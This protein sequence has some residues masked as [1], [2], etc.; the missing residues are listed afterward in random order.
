M[1]SD[2]LYGFNS[3]Q[4]ITKSINQQILQKIRVP[5]P[6]P[7]PLHQITK[8]FGSFTSDFTDYHRWF[9]L[10]ST[11]QQINKSTNSSE[12]P[13]S[14]SSSSSTSPNHQILRGVSPQIS[15][16]ITD[17]LNSIQQI[18]KSINQQ[19]LQKIRVP[20]PLPLPLH[21]ITKF[22]REFHHR[23]FELHSTN[24]QINK[25]PNSSEDPCSSS[26]STSP[27]HQITKSPNSSAWIGYRVSFGLSTTCSFYCTKPPLSKS[28]IT[29]LQ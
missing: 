15:Q 19:I 6:L 4:Q 11:N 21:Q 12:D 22:F 16:I 5:L 29:E 18:N 25:S 1:V 14:S 20:L 8:F 27:N 7:L 2:L 26:S 9:E 24:Q 28:E 10:H 17:G 13:C 3:I 23:W